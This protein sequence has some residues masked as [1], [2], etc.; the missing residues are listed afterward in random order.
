MIKSIIFDWGGV[1][2]E[3]PSNKI[4]SYCANY[5]DVSYNS[6]YEEYRKYKPIFQ[7]GLITE[8]MLWENICN[9]LTLKIPRIKSL[10]KEAFK[11]AYN[12]RKKVFSVVKKL[13]EDG[14]KIGF[15]SNTELPSVEFFN[16]LDY[17]LFDI[18]VFSCFE[19]VRK[20]ELKIYDIIIGKLSLNPNEILFIDDSIEN[21]LAANQI[22]INT[23]QYKDFNQFYSEL[24][25]S[26]KLK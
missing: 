14:F 8:N 13:K 9:E 3:S 23:I 5:L 20:P 24:N 25:K 1:L 6:M 21:I 10:W 26:I 11:A 2:I 7:K 4:I 17:D 12:E 18:L 19:G 15:L 22:G 16:E